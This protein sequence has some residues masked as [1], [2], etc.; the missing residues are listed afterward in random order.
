M[1]P[2]RKT[3]QAKAGSRPVNRRQ[4]ASE[5]RR[6]AILEAALEVFAAEGFAAARLD[7]VAAKAG[8]AK[9][10][11]YLFFEDKEQLFEQLLVSAIAP[12]LSKVEAL[13]AAPSSSLDEVLEATFA[14]F[15]TEVLATPRREVMRLVLK[16]G[17][18]FPRI[19]EVYHREAV[20]KGL[21]AIRQIAGK[22][23]ERG[24]ITSGEIERFPQL[25]FA[26]LLLAVVWEGLFSRL[27]PLDVEG[28]LAA[29]RSLLLGGKPRRRPRRK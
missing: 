16:E 13:A 1:K 2:A 12:V 10:T 8:V 19:A 21:A 11:I 26:P 3:K 7:D 6:K 4:S 9:G 27:E 25:V 15:R 22:A 14:Q 20:A 23:R 29:H 24:E 18:R 5:Q 17:Q 28:L